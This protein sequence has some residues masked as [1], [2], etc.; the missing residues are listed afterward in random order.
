MMTLNKIARTTKDPKKRYHLFKRVAGRRRAP[1][2]KR[3]RGLT[4]TESITKVVRTYKE[5][6]TG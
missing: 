1:Q 6:Y 2:V 5:K 3:I 4:A